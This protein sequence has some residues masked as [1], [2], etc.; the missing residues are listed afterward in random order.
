MTFCG[1][2]SCRIAKSLASWSVTCLPLASLTIASTWDQVYGDAN[3]I[4]RTLLAESGSEQEHAGAPGEAHAS[5]YNRTSASVYRRQR[6]C[7]RLRTCMTVTFCRL[8]TC[9]LLIGR[10]LKKN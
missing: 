4:F 7:R 10:G 8:K 5:A 1:L 2:P 9:T 3:R 6:G